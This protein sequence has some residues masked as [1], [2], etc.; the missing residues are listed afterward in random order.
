VSQLQ[1]QAGL[2]LEQAST[3]LALPTLNQVYETRYAS[4]FPSGILSYNITTTQQVKLSYSRRITRPGPGQLNP[5]VWRDD[6]RHEFHGNPDLRPEYTD[7]FELGLQ[8]ARAWGSVQLNPYVRRTAN[9]VRY[10]QSVDTSGVTVGT[11]DNVARTLTAGADLNVNYHRGPVTFFG[12]GSAYR[13]TSDAA[14]LAGDLSTRAVVW[15]ARLNGTWKLSPVTDLQGF[16]NYRAAYATEGGSQNAF[17]FMN[18]AVRRKLWGDQGSVTL[19]VADP[20]N[21][22]SYGYRTLDA[23][24]DEFTQRHFGVRGLFITVSRNFGQQLKLR[25]RQQEPEATAAPGPP[26]P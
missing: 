23:R 19:R 9:A 22:M 25:P 21:L 12:G 2:R 10:I 26:G 4:A 18:A 20:F 3:R 13:Y 6:A 1:A 5:T 14:N 15:S 17:V 24:V 16:A 8:D 7:A 11:F